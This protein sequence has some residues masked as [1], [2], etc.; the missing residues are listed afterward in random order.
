MSFDEFGLRLIG[1]LAWPV[2]F[3]WSMYLVAD[4]LDTYLRKDSE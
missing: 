1:I 4:V 3:Y 2:A